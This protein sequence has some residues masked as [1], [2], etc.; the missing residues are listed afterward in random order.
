MNLEGYRGRALEFLKSKGLNVGDKVRLRAKGLQLEGVLMPSYSNDDRIV[1]I[2]LNNGYNIGIS[3]ENIS[4]IELIEHFQLKETETKTSDQFKKSEVKIISTGG[5]IAS[6]I[7]Y[8]TGAVRPAL[9][10]EE[11]IEFE[12]EIREI[13]EISS[14]VLMAILSE[15]M[16]PE[17]WER[18][19]DAIARAFNEGN[20]GVVVAHGTDTMT[21]TAA[22]LAFSLPSLPGPVVLVGSQRSSDRPSSDA[23]INL[24]AAVYTAKHAPFGEVVIA[25]H[26]T[27][28]DDYVLIHRGVKVRKMHTSRRDAFQTIN[29]LPLAKFLWSEKEL[30]LL[31]S[32][33]KRKGELKVD[34]KFDPRVF[35]LKFYPG[36]PVDTVYWL[37]DRGFKG[38][39]VEGTGL[40][41]TASEFAEAFKY[42][43]EKGVFV[44]MTS[45]CLFGRVN[46]NVYT[47]GRQLLRAGV[48]PLED[49]LPEVAVVKLMW[50][51]AHH[52]TM[53]ELK[54][55]M[56]TNVAGEINARHL[57]E[58]FPRWYHG[59]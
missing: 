58:Y 10:T 33:Y 30:K 38:I 45:Q 46:M 32:D 22:A 8:E 40:G 28:S 55:F 59:T 42:A 47:T 1:V 6:K 14:E 17:Y 4:E 2:K 29:G 36:M 31:S 19:A 44:G 5:T 51:L 34:A 35:L 52:K 16:K 39:I 11:I 25:M 3:I 56:I 41:H 26:G 13:G 21:F 23:S 9:S 54:S 57:E 48:V 43:T 53:E 7:E 37:T 50:G 15:N 49:M 12:P 20:V 18:V 27:T 24:Y